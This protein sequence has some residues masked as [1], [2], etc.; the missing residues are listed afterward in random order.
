VPVIN[1]NDTVATAELRYGD[2]DRLAGRVAQMISADCLVILSD[3]DGLYK[4]DPQTNPDAE[5]IAEVRALDQSL[6]DMAGG[7][8][9]RHGSGGMRTKLEAA[10]IAVGAGCRMVISNGHVNR[11]L[12]A[13]QN[14][15]RATWFLATSSPQA[16]RKQ[17]IAGS[18]KPK[19]RIVVD[20]GAVRALTQGRS[21]LP[22]GVT[23]IEGSFE[24]G[25]SVSVVNALGE[26]LARGLVAYSRKEAAAIA[27][28]R[29]DQAAEILGYRGRNEIIHRD[30]LV[31]TRTEPRS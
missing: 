14:G 18:L 16:A 24:K 9:S 6:L 17:W 23:A 15:A 28:K 20:E 1:E 26:E 31:L 19:G 27:G 29:S 3:V 5:H 25:D 22:A 10:R 7:P 13:L 21:L 8:G 2:N 30:D 12:Q 4:A 11:P